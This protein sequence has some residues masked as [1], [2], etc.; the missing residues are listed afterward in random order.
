DGQAL[1]P[2]GEPLPGGELTFPEAPH[3]RLSVHG[4]VACDGMGDAQMA[5]LSRVQVHVNG[6]QQLPAVLAPPSPGSRLRTFQAEIHLTRTRGNRISLRLPPTDTPIALEADSRCEGVVDCTRPVPETRQLA[7][8]L[9]IDPS[10][11]DP[12]RVVEGALGALGASG[13]RE[14]RF[15]VPFCDE[16]GLLYGPLVGE[17]VTRE[18]VL[19]QLLLIGRIVQLRARSGAAGDVV[20]VYYRG[21][22]LTQGGLHYWQTQA[23]RLS[24]DPRYSA[25]PCA[26]LAR[27]CG[28]MPG[29]LLVRPAVAPN[30]PA[31]P[32]RSAEARDTDPLA[33]LDDPHVALFRFTWQGQPGTQ[34][35]DARLLRSLARAMPTACTL[36]QLR[37]QLAGGFRRTPSRR[38]PWP[39]IRYRDRV[40]YDEDL[41]D[42][43]RELAIRGAGPAPDSARPLVP[44]PPE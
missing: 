44:P 8:V 20:I 32:V 18:A 6:R 14:N 10:E 23:N 5:A 16:G 38:L 30:P 9:I 28:Q 3:G 36:G 41:P 35:E 24:P 40:L 43:R 7:H 29:T 12:K 19:S 1:V 4:S 31:E 13:L 2:A 27:P 34:D 37:T 42:A 15:N 21:Q 33:G 39:S 25:L 11:G 17:A 26:Q 22:Q